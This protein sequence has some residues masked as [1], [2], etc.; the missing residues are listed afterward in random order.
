MSAITSTICNTLGATTV[1]R[2]IVGII[3]AVFVTLSLL[4][5]MQF[6]I[7]T[8]DRSLDDSVAG[9]MVDFVR[10]KKDESVQRKS[11]KPEKPPL[12]KAPPPEPPQPQLDE[13]TPQTE[14]IGISPV[15]VNPE[16]ELSAGGFS[17]GAGEGDYLPIVKVAPVYPQRALSRGIE[18]F[19]VVEFTVTKLGTVKDVKVID[20]DP[21]TTMFHRSA[22]RAALKFKYKPRVVNGEAV[23][24]PG[25]RNIITF[26]LEK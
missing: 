8:A 1:S 13:I 14:A 21:K 17:F 20:S 12:P 2:V 3:L 18:G 9:R 7:A 15:E 19:V 10:L 24:V 16:I 23:E 6:L 26:K 22:T 4:W 11:T 5:T 25:V